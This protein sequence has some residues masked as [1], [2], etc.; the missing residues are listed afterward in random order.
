MIVEGYTLHS[1]GY[2][3]FLCLV[4]GLVMLLVDA[5]V[6]KAEAAGKPYKVSRA[7]GWV[8]LALGLLLLLTMFIF[9]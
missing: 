5:R 2:I 1:F 7:L 6:Y 9:Y 4:S 8:N 3:I